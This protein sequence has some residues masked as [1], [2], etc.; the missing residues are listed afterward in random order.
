MG[1]KPDPTGH[2]DEYSGPTLQAPHLPTFA[3]AKNPCGKN[4]IQ[5]G[6]SPRLQFGR[7]CLSP[8]KVPEVSF[9]CM[10]DPSLRQ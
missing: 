1:E 5:A 4:H 3:F 10:E 9:V 8:P 2:A 7:D 6:L